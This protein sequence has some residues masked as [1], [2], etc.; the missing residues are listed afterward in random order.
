MVIITPTKYENGIQ[1][2][3]VN[4]D[5]VKDLGIA[6]DTELKFRK[7]ISNCI[8][9]GNRVI[10]LIRRSFLHI[11]NKSFSKLYKT[12]IRPHLEY[13]NIIWNPRLKKDIEAIERVQIRATKLVH[14]VR[15]L[16]YSNRLKVLKISSSTY[17]R[18]PGDMIQVYKLLHNLE[19]IPSTRFFELNENPTRG[20]ALKL[21]KKSCK[22]EIH[23]NFF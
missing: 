12:L 7:H 13:G 20:H 1:K 5:T 11:T 16:S 22:K 18:F 19:D 8:N 9:K 10:C 17:R 23:K 3:I 21:K 4:N 14:N 2:E 6:F 15:N